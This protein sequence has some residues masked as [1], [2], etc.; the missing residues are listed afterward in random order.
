MMLEPIWL[1]WIDWLKAILLYGG[2]WGGV[3]QAVMWS[4]Q[5]RVVVEL[6]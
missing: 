6:G 3:V 5:T 1:F 4:L 2:C